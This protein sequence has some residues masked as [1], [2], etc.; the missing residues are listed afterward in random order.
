MSNTID[1]QATLLAQ[2]NAVNAK[3]WTEGQL[4]F[5]L[6]TAD[7][8]GAKN[9]VVVV[10]PAAGQPYSGSRSIY[11]NRVG[12]NEIPPGGAAVELELTNESSTHDVVALLASQYSVDLTVDDVQDAPLPAADEFGTV[13]V[14]LQA[15]AASGKW[16]GSLAVTLRPATQPLEN[17]IEENEIDGFDRDGVSAV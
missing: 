14:T 4:V 16:N 8:S 17:V 11:Y 15:A 6:P 1:Y 10:T 2:I 13:E 3:Q 5:G 7:S 9:T 12:L